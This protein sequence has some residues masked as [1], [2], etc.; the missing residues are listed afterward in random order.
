[1]TNTAPD[2]TPVAVRLAVPPLRA[3]PLPA[4][5][6]VRVVVPPLL[7]STAISPLLE[8]VELVHPAP[9]G[10]PNSA[11][12][13]PGIDHLR[14]KAAAWWSWAN[15]TPARGARVS[16]LLGLGLLLLLGYLTPAPAPDWQPALGWLNTS[17]TLGGL[18]W[19]WWWWRGRPLA[20]RLL[21]LCTG[22]VLFPSSLFFVHSLSN[23]LGLPYTLSWYGLLLFALWKGGGFLTRRIAPLLRPAAI[24]PELAETGSLAQPSL[25]ERA[26]SGRVV[27]EGISASGV[28]RIRMVSTAERIKTIYWTMRIG[29]FLTTTVVMIFYHKSVIRY[30][31]SIVGEN[32]PDAAMGLV[33]GLIRRFRL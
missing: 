31:W 30:L 33:E 14:K 2:L 11:G 1:V 26:R 29:L 22:L 18:A 15:V 8:Q 13:R 3:E 7:R 25:L 20:T 10:V 21:A 32:A 12:W 9:R 19:G 27:V 6:V 5:V 17:A 4:P 28:Q 23:G 16:A 24:G